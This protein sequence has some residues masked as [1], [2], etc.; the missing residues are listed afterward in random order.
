MMASYIRLRDNSCLRPPIRTYCSTDLQATSR[1]CW[2]S[3]SSGTN[4][5]ET[6][7]PQ[8]A[9]LT[10][11][12]LSKTYAI[13]RLDPA[14]PVPSWA[15][16][17]D[18]WSLIRTRDELSIVCEEHA[19]PADISRE[20][21]WRILKCEGPLDFALTGIM[22]AIADPLADAGVSIFPLATYDTDYVL[23]KHVQIEIAAQALIDYGHAGNVR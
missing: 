4:I 11:S 20:G 14:M 19:L 21:G 18:F 23:V 3:G 1:Q 8:R 13:C 12:V 17:G 6:Q 2:K 5:E 10:L 16:T 7:M 15:M 22:A 9:M